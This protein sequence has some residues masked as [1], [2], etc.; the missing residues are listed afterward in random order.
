M[1]QIL[2]LLV[3]DFIITT[4]TKFLE[5]KMNVLEINEKIEFLGREIETIKNNPL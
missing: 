5:V 4:M 2:K 1:T 3:K